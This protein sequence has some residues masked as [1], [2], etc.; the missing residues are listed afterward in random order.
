MVIRSTRGLRTVGWRDFFVSAL[1][2]SLSPDE[3]LVEIQVPA[4]PR[5]CGSAFCEFAAR[6]GDFA[7]AAAA[8]VLRLDADGVCQAASLAVLGVGS[9]PHRARS[10][11]EHLVGSDPGAEAARA[12]A[13]AADEL[14]SRSAGDASLE[15]R[16]KLIEHLAGLAIGKAARRAAAQVA[17]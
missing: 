15:Y 3:L 13:A 17:P 6:R 2:T 4:P 14:A 7:L 16:R 9:A 1:T 10:A 8:A 12:A 11:E 5:G